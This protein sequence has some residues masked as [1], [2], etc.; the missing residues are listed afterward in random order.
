MDALNTAFASGVGNFQ[1]ISVTYSD[2]TS[3]YTFTTGAGTT[4]S[5]TILA[6]STMNSVLG[7]E[8]GLVNNSVSNT[9]MVR[10]FLP[11]INTKFGTITVVAGTNDS[12]RITAPNGNAVTITLTAGWNSI[13]SST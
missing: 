13:R 8:Y 9:T 7:F 10:S 11:A 5:L 2:I 6:I 4:Y 3:L 12:L 1:N